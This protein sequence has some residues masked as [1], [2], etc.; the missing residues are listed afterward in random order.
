[1][2]TQNTFDRD[3]LWHQMIA[4]TPQHRHYIPEGIGGHCVLLINTEHIVDITKTTIKC[5]ADKILQNWDQ[6][7]IPRFRDSPPGAAVVKTVTELHNLNNAIRTGTVT[8]QMIN[9]KNEFNLKISMDQIAKVRRELTEALTCTTAPNFEHEFALVFDRRK[10]ERKRDEL[11]F[12]MSK[13]SFQLYPDYLNKLNVLKA[14]A[15]IDEQHEVT[16]K[17]RVACEMG[18]NE[19]II[20]ELVLSNTFTDLEPDEIPALLSALVFQAKTDCEPTLTDNLKRCMEAIKVVNQTIINVET[21]FNV[22]SSDDT[23][24]KDRLNFGL[25]E[26][27]Y[28]WARKKVSVILFV[29][30]VKKNDPTLFSVFCQNYCPD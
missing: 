6:R 23:V 4:L 2:Y 25:V 10:L 15:Y 8:L 17:G 7:Q 12:K 16:M 26:V 1:M 30:L 28:E 19:L 3:P 29:S 11:R 27:V 22:G 5:E 21:R 14:L 24:A 13:E 20:T 9:F 18:S